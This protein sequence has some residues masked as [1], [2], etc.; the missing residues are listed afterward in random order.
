MKKRS[1]IISLLTVIIALFIFACSSGTEGLDKTF[2]PYDDFNGIDYTGVLEIDDYVTIDGVL[3][4]DIWTESK[5]TITVQG[6]KNNSSGNP[7]DENKWG[8]REMTMYTY[9]GEKAIYFAFDVTDRNLFYNEDRPQGASSTVEVYLTSKDHT[10]LEPGCISVRATPTGIGNEVYVEFY[11]PNRTND[12]W[13]DDPTLRRKA[14]AAAKVEGNVVTKQN[15]YPDTSNNKGYCIEMAFDWS[16]VSEEKPDAIQFAASF[17]QPT[18][19]ETARLGNSFIPGTSY[20]NVSSWKLAIN[21]GI[22]QDKNAFFDGEIEL[23]DGVTLDGN[24]DEDVWKDSIFRTYEKTNY[25]NKNG[26]PIKAS[27]ATAHTDKGLYVGIETNDTTVFVDEDSFTNNTGA[28]ILIAANG[29]NKINSQNVVQIRL[30]ANGETVRYRGKT[31]GTGYPYIGGYFP[32]L[33]GARV[34]DGQLNSANVNGWA[35]EIF[36]PWSSLGVTSE[37][38]K[39]NVAIFP[40][41]YLANET[42]EGEQPDGKR[43]AYVASAEVYS[44]IDN[45]QDVW[46]LFKNGKPVYD[47]IDV[48][49]IDFDKSM[50]IENADGNYYETTISASFYDNVAKSANEKFPVVTGA[51]FGFDSS[52][53]VTVTDNGNGTYTIKIPEESESAFATTKEVPFVANGNESTVKVFI[54]SAF[55]LDG[56]LDD[57]CYSDLEKLTIINNSVRYVSTDFTVAFGETAFYLYALTTDELFT[58]YND[59]QPLGLEMYF[60]F[61]ASL[62]SANTY[63][64]R[65][66]S[67]HSTG[68]KNQFYVY[69]DVPDSGGWS[70]SGG[71]ENSQ[72]Q[73]VFVD[74]NNGTYCI[75]AKIPYSVFGLTEK[76]EWVEI[77]P[78]VKYYNA[79]NNT[80][81]TAFFDYE[82]NER[83]SRDQGLYV[84]F[85]DLIGYAPNVYTFDENGI[86]LDKIVLI[87]GV[88]I[89]D[90]KYVGEISLAYLYTGKCAITDATFDKYV[91][92]NGNGKYTFAIPVSEFDGKDSI[93]L[94]F[95]TS[96]TGD[97]KRTLT[98]YNTGLDKL[99]VD[100]TEVK[101]SKGDAVNGKVPVTIGVFADEKLTGA[102]K[103]DVVITSE[104]NVIMDTTM[105][106]S[107]KYTFY[108][109]WESIGESG[110]NF[111]IGAGDGVETATIRVVKYDFTDQEKTAF[112]GNVAT[113]LNFNGNVNTYGNGNATA[114]VRR[115]R[116]ESTRYVN[117]DQ[118]VINMYKRALSVDGITFGSRNDHS[119]QDA[120]GSFTISMDING[121]DLANTAYSG[122][123]IPLF[124]TSRTDGVEDGIGFYVRGAS[125]GKFGMISEMSVMYLKNHNTKTSGYV[126]TASR[127]AILDKINGQGMQ[128]WTI[129]FD[130]T[131]SGKISITIY[132]DGELMTTEPC[133]LAV[134]DDLDIGGANQGKFGIGGGAVADDTQNYPTG[135]YYIEDKSYANKNTDVKIDN[136]IF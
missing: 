26:Q 131:V 124:T 32:M 97:S 80:L 3:D 17:C 57:V 55:L 29:T 28:E 54:E 62:S 132:I 72:I 19:L 130:R 20:I 100:E 35:G 136:F 105:D 53:G 47:K 42:P 12:E 117:N 31:G 88:G 125:N 49:T 27:F 68:A 101:V 59:S 115:D 85:K 94:T 71:K 111:V 61:G 69:K 4:E 110:I 36:I 25:T 7:I 15:P 73:R 129:V 116:D 43:R 128:N 56:K 74:N 109:D 98:I 58:T 78:A 63:Q 34:I 24:F 76:P 52:L 9:I 126:N 134:A 5:T 13:E 11:I 77:C 2:K 1:F 41:L 6:A 51:T 127:K 120:Y 60:N 93:D 44:E 37:E 118:Y 75:E 14:V 65:L 107:G 89:V 83:P 119:A 30:L 92:N 8:K 114:T 122:Y 46:Y 121:A 123:G 96:L 40:C 90:D 108:V 18:G 95:A 33:S 67:Y 79:N 112:I 103:S 45:P 21:D 22:I 66:L 102:V 87:D 38:G 48:G 82:G 133:T 106:A 70:W 99:Y 64:V 16:L 81:R 135:E 104:S 84:P 10:T 86:S 113:Y 50:L 91:T 23:D 39:Q